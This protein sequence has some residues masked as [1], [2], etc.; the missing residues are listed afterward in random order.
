MRPQTFTDVPSTRKPSSL[1]LRLQA[2]ADEPRPNIGG[3]QK[4]HPN[5]AQPCANSSK[6]CI[7]R[8]SSRAVIERLERAPHLRLGPALGAM[9]LDE[10]PDH[11]RCRLLLQ[12]PGLPRGRRA[13]VDADPRPCDVC[14]RRE[15]AGSDGRDTFGASQN[16][17]VR[18]CQTDLEEARLKALKE[19]V[20]KPRRTEFPPGA[21]VFDTDPDAGPSCAGC[22]FRRRQHASPRCGR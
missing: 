14:R 18:V 22:C 4:N 12:I 5:P 7:K 17:A 21:T 16:I 2:G 6:R 10:S 8:V 1:R 11:A 20:S 19:Y 13:A 15:R 3:I 9:S